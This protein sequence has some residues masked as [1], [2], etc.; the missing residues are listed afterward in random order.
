MM[1]LKFCYVFLDLDVEA[2]ELIQNLASKLPQ[3]LLINIAFQE[4]DQVLVGA[5][6]EEARPVRLRRRLPQVSLSF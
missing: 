2:L 5:L 4:E 3:I 6:P 1:M